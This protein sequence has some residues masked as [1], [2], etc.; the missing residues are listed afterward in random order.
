MP[1]REETVYHYRGLI[2]RGKD[3]HWVEGWSATGQSG[4][5]L[6]PWMTKREC[7]QQAKRE[8]RK[9]VFA[10]ACAGDSEERS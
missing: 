8:G 2:E 3:Y 5:I 1:K 10:E 6:F 7:Q 9:A 4:G